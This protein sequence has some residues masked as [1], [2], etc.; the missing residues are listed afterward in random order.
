MSANERSLTTNTQ[1]NAGGPSPANTGGPNQS[2]EQNEP[3]SGFS[4]FAL[5]YKK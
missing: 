2:D 5:D 4:I 1:G 3:T